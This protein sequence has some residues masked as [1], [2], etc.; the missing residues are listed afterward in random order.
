MIKI[1]FPPGCYGHYI[2]RCIYYFTNLRSGEFN[3]FEFELTGAS[4]SIR[5]DNT[6]RQHVRIGHFAYITD[7]K[8]HDATIQV[9][10]D[11]QAVVVLPTD[12]HWLDYYNNQFIKQTKNNLVWAVSEQ[13]SIEELRHKLNT[14]WQYSGEFD[15]TV[16]I[17]ILRELFSFLIW[18]ILVAGYSTDRCNIDR[19]SIINAQDLFDDYSTV[20]K[21]LCNQLG[22]EITVPDNRILQ[23]HQQF[24]QAQL[25]HDSQWRCQQWVQAVID[26]IELI[27]CP[28]RTLFDE[29]YIQHCFRTAGYEIQCDGLNKFPAYSHDMTALIF[30]IK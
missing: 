29:A 30:K 21:T 5:T 15:T 12:G 28:A 13:L 4:H 26:S 6:L 7:G 1:C 2:G 11:E 10:P 19:A 16:P 8:C 27:P 9:L 17:W 24:I 18:D 14:Q 20:F 25:Y 22:L 23:N 3:D